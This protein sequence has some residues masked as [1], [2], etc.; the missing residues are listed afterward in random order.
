MAAATLGTFT[1]DELEYICQTT[2]LK[3]ELDWQDR[4]ATAQGRSLKA[5]RREGRKEGLTQG[6]KEGRSEASL[7]IARKMKA[8]G[9]SFVEI[10]E[11]TGLSAETIARL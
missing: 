6:R 9:R 1:Q 2:L 11:D 4:D 5:G 10:A 8:R 3:G 7:D